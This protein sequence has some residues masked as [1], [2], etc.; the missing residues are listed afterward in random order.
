[1]LNTMGTVL[2]QRRCG[3]EARLLRR[4]SSSS[5]TASS[6]SPKGELS[7]SAKFLRFGKEH[8]PFATVLLAFLGSAY[9]LGSSISSVS[10]ERELRQKDV[11]HFSAELAKERELRCS[12]LAKERE[13]RFSELAK[14]R[15]LRSSDVTKERDMRQKDVELLSAK[16]DAEIRVC[17]TSPPVSHAHTCLAPCP[18]RNIVLF[19]ETRI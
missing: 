8:A 17:S 4:L 13:L 12:E 18:L 1:M 9:G 15:E 11:E 16:L 5:T 10:K 19:A 2:A 7:S 14:E 3:G 6:E